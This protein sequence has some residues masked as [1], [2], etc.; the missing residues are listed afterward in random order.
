MVLVLVLFTV[1][2]GAVGEQQA[3]REAIE[4]FCKLYWRRG[5]QRRG[6]THK[7]SGEPSPRGDDIGT[8][9]GRHGRNLLRK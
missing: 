2:G 9:S 1:G 3:H 5:G 8:R 4:L 6:V 7:R